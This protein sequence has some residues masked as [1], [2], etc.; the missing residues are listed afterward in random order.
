MTPLAY[1]A[2]NFVMLKAQNSNFTKK[3]KLQIVLYINDLKAEL[4]D[5]SIERQLTILKEINELNVYK[6]TLAK[7]IGER[8][9]TPSPS[10]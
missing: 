6:L 4:K 10:Q 1:D 3:D 9:I 8:V 2:L 7:L 5:A